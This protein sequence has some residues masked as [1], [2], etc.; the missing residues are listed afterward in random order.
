MTFY[1]NIGIYISLS[2]GN[3]ISKYVNMTKLSI[4]NHLELQHDI[5]MQCENH[6]LRKKRD[7]TD[8]L[9]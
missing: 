1:S 5:T 2:H 8:V 6:F 7:K 3:E 9:F 4:S